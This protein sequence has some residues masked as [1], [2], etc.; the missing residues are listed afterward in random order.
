VPV[1]RAALRR[2]YLD[3]IRAGD[4]GAALELALAPL[5]EGELGLAPFYDDVLTPVAAQV[6]DLWHIGAISVADEHFATTVHREAQQQ[7]RDLFDAAEPNG[8]VA[9]LA[10][11]PEEQHELGLQM[12]ANVLRLAGYAV[13]LLG[14]RM[15]ARDLARFVE[16]RTPDVVLLSCTTPIT[17]TGL[18]DA[19]RQVRAL[20]VPTLVG[21]RA[22]RDYPA[23][24][25]AAEADATCAALADLVGVVDAL[26]SE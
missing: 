21:G 1:E 5:R 13:E 8:R 16:Q 22:V 12:A 19:V 2:D 9:V 26:V 11:A 18:I 4:R 15:P 10:C 20:G 14:A 6:G 24:A 25:V 7:A 3:Q 23:I 17:I